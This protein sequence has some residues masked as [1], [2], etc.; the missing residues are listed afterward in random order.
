MQREIVSRPEPPMRPSAP[1]HP[2]RSRRNP[3][4]KDAGRVPQACG[5]LVDGQGVILETEGDTQALLGFAPETLRSRH[6]SLVL[7]DMRDVTLIE[8]GQLNAR[9]H[10][11]CHVGG[12]FRIT[13]GGGGTACGYLSLIDLSSAN[14]PRVRLLVRRAEL[15]ECAAHAGPDRPAG[16]G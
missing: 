1:V 8:H 7:P 2:L 14:R 9:L 6:V 3:V 12:K 5:L 13:P 10:F 16:T 11:L 4:P 15:C